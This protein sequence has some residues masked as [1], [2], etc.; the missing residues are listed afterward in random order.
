MGRPTKMS[1]D[2]K[3]K[4]VDAYFL[5]HREETNRHGIYA[6]IANYARSACQND[7]IYPHDFS[8]DVKVRDHIERKGAEAWKETDKGILLAYMPMDIDRLQSM[9]RAQ[10]VG[11]LRERDAYYATVYDRAARAIEAGEK[12]ERRISKLRE[13]SKQLKADLDKAKA[14]QVG[15]ERLQIALKNAK[16]EIETLKRHIRR[17]MEPEEADAYYRTICDNPKKQ[18]ED[19]IAFCTQDLWSTESDC[20]T[21]G[22][23]EER[24]DILKLL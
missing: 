19:T 8:K 18:L 4:I 22:A 23:R 24:M 10:L 7:N 12:S 16:Q 21:S 20:D 2:E 5:T 15:E 11:Y 13:E 6:R 9:G 14:S 1:C 3:R 17:K